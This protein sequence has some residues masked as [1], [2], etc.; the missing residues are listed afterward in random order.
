MT[1]PT[2]TSQWDLG[3]YKPLDMR[4]IPG[5]PRQMPPISKKRWLPGFTGGNGERADFHMNDFYSYFMLDP[6]A[7][8]AKDVVM[9]LFAH[10]LHGNAKKWYNSLPNDNI[11][12]MDQLEEVFLEEWGIRSKYIPILQ[13]KIEDIK[14]S[15]NETL[16]DFQSRFEGTLHQIP[17]SHH[18]G[19]EYV[20][21]IYTHAILAH[22][23]LPLRRRAPKTLNE[24]YGMAKEI[25]QNIFSSGIKDLFTSGTLTMEI[26]Y[27]HE[28]LTDDLQEE[29]KQTIIQH[30][31]NEDMDGEQE[32]EQD[33]EVST[34]APPSDETI[35]EP[36]S[37]AQQNEDEVSCFSSRDSN[38]TL[39]HD[40]ESEEEMEA[41]DEVDVPCCAIKDKEAIH[42]DEAIMHA[43]N[44][45]AIRAPAQEETVSYPPPLNVDDA[46]PCDEKEE[47]DEF[48]NFTN[49]TCYDTDSDTVDNI[50]EFIHVGR[51]RWDVVGYDL[52]PIY[53]IEGRFQ[54]FPLQLPQ[55]I[56][57]DQWQQGDEV[58][59]CSFQKTKDDLVPYFSDDFQ[60]YL[61]FFYEY[62]PEHLDYFHE[63]DCQPLLCS[64]FKTSKDI[65]CL[66]KVSH[67]FSPQPPDIT[68]PCFSIKGVVGK[69]L[70]HVDFPPWQTLDFKGWLGNTS[71]NQFFNFPLII[72][73]S[74]TKLLSILSL[75]CEDV[76]GNQSTGPLSPFF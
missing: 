21:H 73:Q 13:K 43:E 68:L 41:L 32:P 51:R 65:V 24:A 3:S 67:D 35:Q 69:Y 70:F 33:D 58:F 5:Y 45:K 39:F 9:K 2:M 28:N 36:F 55:Q 38:D 75:E 76:L 8:E 7:D 25:K 29:G 14:Q 74:S 15:E 66:K 16:F 19:E 1:K 26:L 34:C 22:L 4:K 23:G 12:S 71:S 64:D 42:D 18:P 62:P 48:L 44:T 57:S 17:A 72:C 56:T 40:S 59:T 30:R 10:T 37:P 49:P 60:S 52:D 61:E 63:D 46:L 27:S 6:V 11:T 31:V 53:D 47:E 20:V 50:D 54:L